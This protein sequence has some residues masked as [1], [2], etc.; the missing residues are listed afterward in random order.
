MTT[1]QRVRNHVVATG[2]VRPLVYSCHVISTGLDLDRFQIARTSMVRDAR[3]G[4]ATGS[5]ISSSPE[6]PSGAAEGL[7]A[8]SL[9]GSVVELCKH[10]ISLSS[11][12]KSRI[13]Q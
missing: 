8:S 7:T 13:A 10:L 1:I 2:F 6:R 12:G 11:S 9:C 3:S 5:V 4:I